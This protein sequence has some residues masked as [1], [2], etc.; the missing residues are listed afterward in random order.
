MNAAV[1]ILTIL[2]AAWVA[3]GNVEGYGPWPGSRA[4]D[5]PRPLRSRPRDYRDFEILTTPPEARQPPRPA[6]SVGNIAAALAVVNDDSAPANGSDDI[7]V[8]SQTAPLGFAP[9]Y[10][11]IACPRPAPADD[12]RPPIPLALMRAEA[13]RADPDM[14]YEGQTGMCSDNPYA[15]DEAVL[16]LG[17][18]MYNSGRDPTSLGRN[19]SGVLYGVELSA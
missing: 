18:G 2:L 17:A 9:D 5:N 14:A 13:G 6:L 4:A 19:V 16:A 11:E 3:A 1:A 7:A 12:H 15:E 8:V 10:T